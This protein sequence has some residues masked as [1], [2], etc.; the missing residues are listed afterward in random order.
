MLFFRSLLFNIIYFFWI[1]GFLGFFYPYIWFLPVSFCV[2]VERSYV[3]GFLKILNFFC[4][5]D[6]IVKGQSHLDDA[7][8][9]G[10]CI[11]ACLHQSLWETMIFHIL[12][13][14]A[15]F[16][17]KKELFSIPIFGGYLKRGKSIK[18]DRKS[19]STKTI[20]HLIDQGKEAAKLGFSIVIFPQGKRVSYHNNC[21]EVQRGITFLYNHLKLP[22]LPVVL[23]S[24]KFWKRRGFF[25]YPGTITLEYLPIIEPNLEKEDMLHQLQHTLQNGFQNLKSRHG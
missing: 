23:N 24:G 5:I 18:V 15:A 9:N 8:E 22:I 4:R 11:V 6:Y 25:K 19:S 1:F 20:R 17:A 7:L 14:K 13:P 21:I 16:V 3:R 10:P 12:L 2:W